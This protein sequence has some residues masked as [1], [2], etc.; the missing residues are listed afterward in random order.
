LSYLQ[1]L[2]LDALKID[3]SFVRRINTNAGETTIV[4]A[5]INMG[6]SLN[7]RVIAEGVET[8]GDLAFLKAHH[9]DE[10][11]GFYF[12]KPVPAD[13][14]ASFFERHKSRS[15]KGSPGRVSEERT[16]PLAGVG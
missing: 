13:Q 15:F 7:L 10:A 4:S 11:Q 5:I 16:A 14:F 9:C 1:K 8:V 3:Q 12:S 6:R 2:P